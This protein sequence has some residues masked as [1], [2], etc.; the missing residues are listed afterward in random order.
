MFYSILTQRKWMA[1][2]MALSLLAGACAKVALVPSDKQDEPPFSDNSKV[3]LILVD[4]VVGKE[5]RKVST[6]VIE[7]LKPNSIYSYESLADSVTTDGASLANIMTATTVGNNETRDSS[8]TPRVERG[9]RYPSFITR[10]KDQ[11][12]RPFR[13]V[14]ATSWDALTKTYFKDADV[15]ITTA[16]NNNDAVRDS[17]INRLRTDSADLLIA[18]FSSANIAGRM[19][20]FSASQTAYKDALLKVDAYIGALID[21]MKARTKYGEEDWLVII[22]STHGGIRNTYGG[23][24]E[25]ERNAFTLYYNA[26]FK[27]REVLAPPAVRS[28]VK[29]YGSDASAVNAVLT[30]AAAYN[31]GDKGEFTFE[32][33]VRHA[34]AG[35]NVTYPSFFS[36]RN[37]FAGGVPGW[38]FF[39]ENAYWMCNVGQVGKN[40]VQAKG[41][42]IN[43]GRWHHLSAVVYINASNRRMIR[44]YTD[45][46]FNEEKDITDMGNINSPA[47]VTIGPTLPVNGSMMDIYVNDVRIWNAAL[48]PK[49]IADYACTNKIDASHPNYANLAGYWGAAEGSGDKFRN[50]ISGAPDFQLRNAFRWEAADVLLSCGKAAP[51]APYCR[52]TFHQIAYWMNLPVLKDWEIDGRLWLAQ[53]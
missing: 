10:V 42:N 15:K 37:N 48:T 11:K 32:I 28:G 53:L 31:P 6:P 41:A 51:D 1:G 38:C 35:R 13:V 45:G 4:G 5:L 46:A 7:S 23:F 52:E 24:G 43:D 33:K 44:T 16:A 47:P 49:T 30:D 40:N 22:Q 29:L 34:V 8:L 19:S 26:S 3:L 27:T 25:T 14:T 20:E 17:V 9:N 50:S 39:Q 18:H 2:I 21:A 12:F 36:K